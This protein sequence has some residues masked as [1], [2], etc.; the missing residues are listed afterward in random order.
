M[1]D[2][3]GTYFFSESS[4]YEGVRD[5][6]KLSLIVTNFFHYSGTL[7]LV[8]E[9]IGGYESGVREKQEWKV[10]GQRN[11]GNL[12]EINVSG[13]GNYL[14]SKTEKGINWTFTGRPEDWNS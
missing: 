1:I 7:D 4:S 10:S 2:F 6:Y 12:L 14:L 11:I 8:S 3:S 9:P 5:S 13:K